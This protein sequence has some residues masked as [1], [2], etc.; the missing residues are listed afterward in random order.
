MT[1]RLFF[2][3]AGPAL[4]EGGHEVV[5]FWIDPGALHGRHPDTV[6]HNILAVA[7]GTLC[8]RPG[9]LTLLTAAEELDQ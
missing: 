5:G 8:V 2:R 7:G 4:P 6:A 9:L 1:R 3:F